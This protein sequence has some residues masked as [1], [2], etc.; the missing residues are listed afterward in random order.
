MTRGCAHNRYNRQFHYA[1]KFY[2]VVMGTSVVIINLQSVSP[3]I[4][5]QRVYFALL[6]LVVTFQVRAVW[7]TAGAPS[8]Q[9]CARHV[10]E[11]TT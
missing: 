7:R 6:A 1:C 11:S 10:L 8:M 3:F 4:A 9:D 5:E 2:L